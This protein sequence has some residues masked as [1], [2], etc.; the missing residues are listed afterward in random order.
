MMTWAPCISCGSSWSQLRS[1]SDSSAAAL[2]NSRLAQCHSSSSRASSG[3]PP[4]AAA[5]F[6]G[7]S[8]AAPQQKTQ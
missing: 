8:L 4:R 2:A 5:A 1:D 7:A 6:P 3:D